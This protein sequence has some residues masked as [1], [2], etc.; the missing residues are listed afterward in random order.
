MKSNV[1]RF[2]ENSARYAQF[3]PQYPDEMV[4]E[5][6][7]RILAIQ[8][9]PTLPVL[10]IG[11]GSGIFTRQLAAYL[12]AETPIIGIEP[13][14]AMRE[15]AVVTT[16]LKAVTYREGTA[17]ALPIENGAAPLRPSENRADIR[18]H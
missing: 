12:P 14:S 6:A 3:R 5:L 16:N 10:D 8:A 11:S 4:G 15:Q 1:E 2:Q 7:N 9:P 13:A 17:E 18:K